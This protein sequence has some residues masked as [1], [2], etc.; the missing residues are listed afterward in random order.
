MPRKIVL[1]LLLLAAGVGVGTAESQQWRPP[2]REMPMM[3]Q[4]AELT[5]DWLGPR[6]AWFSGVAELSG[7]QPSSLSVTG[8]ARPGTRQTQVVRFSNGPLPVV[9]WQD[10]N[11]DSRAD[12]V[13]IFRGGRVVVQVIDADYDGFANVIRHYDA[14]GTLIREDRL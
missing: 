1:A 7:V 3:P 9:V 13:E 14:S 12:M 6:A 5:G 11:G 10:R 8:E 4:V 2:S